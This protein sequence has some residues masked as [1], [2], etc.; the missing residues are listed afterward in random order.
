MIINLTG[1]SREE[2]LKIL[3]SSLRNPN[4]GIVRKA[5]DILIKDFKKDGTDIFIEAL[6]DPNWY[7][8]SEAVWALE[9]IG[10]KKAIEPLKK[11]LSDPVRRVYSSSGEVLEKFGWYPVTF[12]EKVAYFFAR[13]N[14]KELIKLGDDGFQLLLNTLEKLP[15]SWDL[16]CKAAEALGII[17]DR[18]AVIPLI[19][20]LDFN[21]PVV[22]VRSAEALGKIGDNMAFE[23]LLKLLKKDDPDL[24]RTT[25]EAIGKLGL[26]EALPVILGELKSPDPEMRL[27]AVKCLENLV[28][29]KSIEPLK[30]IIIKDKNYEIKKIAIK[31]LGKIEDPEP[32]LFLMNLLDTS[33]EELHESILEGLGERGDKRAC[34]VIIKSLESDYPEIRFQAARVLGKIGDRESI[35]CLVKT[36]EDPDWRVCSEA[37]K[38]LGCLKDPSSL[39]RLKEYLSHERSYIRQITVK[40]ISN[41]GEKAIPYLVPLLRDR[42]NYVRLVTALVLEKLDWMSQEPEMRAA[43]YFAR[44][45]LPSLL[46]EGEEGFKFLIK[47]LGDSYALIK[48]PVENFILSMG[49]KAKNLLLKALKNEEPQIRAA[50]LKLMGKLGMEEEIILKY[51]KDDENNS[52]RRTA[53][54]A[55]RGFDR[56]DEILEGLTIALK[57]RDQGVRNTAEKSLKKIKK[58]TGKRSDNLFVIKKELFSS[59]PVIN[60]LREEK[61]YSYM[62]MIASREEK[63]EKNPIEGRNVMD[64]CNKMNGDYYPDK[65]VNIV[66]Y[67]PKIP[68]NTGNIA[69][70]CAGTGC[71][72]YLVGNLG[73]S[74]KDRALKRAG[75]DYWYLTRM[76]YYQS[77]SDLYNAFPK[78]KFFYFT[79]NTKK[80]YTAVSYKT[81]DFLVFGPERPGLPIE[82]LKENT[83][84][85]V[86]IPMW[87]EARS[88]N[89]ATSV[90][91]ALYEALRQL[92]NGWI[93]SECN[94]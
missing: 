51:L 53:A 43:Y 93:G 23:P 34:P 94:G 15:H 82:M 16:A 11:A 12:E 46:K 86:S 50:A 69:R 70:L 88:F 71:V 36:L 24:G 85:T 8:R 58:S 27:I 63:Q 84:T 2:S 89:L 87:G 26:M 1:K 75:L 45:D 29:K 60:E 47:G 7:V 22:S 41:M 25:L 42:H 9:E 4:L 66:L 33:P 38:A 31:A 28:H 76:F 18:R 59:I 52:V 10:D 73:F 55:L 62:E 21:I 65:Y 13:G 74:L 56:N 5:T 57:D 67:E 39:E 68:P 72:L 77:M 48:E 49:D 61:E 92:N 78:S 79:S 3:S 32:V 37:L 81:G 83:E 91:I 54:G 44:R 30:D 40:A 20:T 90:G 35:F 14:F 17:G 19:R 80:P 6:S 64:L